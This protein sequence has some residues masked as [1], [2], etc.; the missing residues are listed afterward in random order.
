MTGNADMNKVPE[1]V[2]TK[3]VELYTALHSATDDLKMAS[4]EACLIGDFSQV[5]IINDSCRKLQALE[6]EIKASVNNFDARY[7]AR[8]V[9]KT[10]FHKKDNN[11]TRKQGGRLR[12][13]LAGKVIEQHTIAETFVE[14]LKAFGLERVAK[15]NKTVTSIPLIARTPTSNYQTQ[16]RCDGWFIT[17]HV[18]K[19]SATTVLE[20]IAKALNM[21]LKVECIER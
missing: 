11:R 9:E 3:F 7:T 8:S 4:A 10:V 14:T 12:V 18:N 5:T 21:P 6:S 16:K 17:T 2:T 1:A 13:T 20:E 19:V 15:L